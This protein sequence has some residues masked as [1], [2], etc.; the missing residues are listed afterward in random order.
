MAYSNSNSTRERDTEGPPCQSQEGVSG[1][2]K[3]GKLA[4]GGIRRTRRR[5][6]PLIF[7]QIPAA[8]WLLK[9]PLP[10]MVRIKKGQLNI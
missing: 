10:T 9:G 1:L 5:S 3:G 7:A 8:K 2:V 6:E 4:V